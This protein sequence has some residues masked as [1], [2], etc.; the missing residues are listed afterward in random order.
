MTAG[1]PYS[2]QKLVHHPE[3]LQAM[4]EERPQAPIQ[5]HFMPALA[6]NQHCEFCS[7]GHRVEADGEEQRGWKNMALMSAEYLP[8]LK[9]LEL[10][11]DWAEMGVKAVE[12][13][14]GGEP[15]IYPHVDKFLERMADWRA[16]IA[17]VTNGTALTEERCAKFAA[18]NWK[19]ARVSIDAGKRET[20]AKVR[21]V[22][23]SHWDLA[24]RAVR[25]LVMAKSSREQRVGVGYVV[26]RHNAT[27]TDVYSAA[28]LAV[29][30]GADN[31]R[32]SLAF[33]PQHMERF[34]VE[35]MAAVQLGLRLARQEFGERF[36]IID[37][38]TERA[39]NI[40][41]AVQD[42]RMCAAK[43]VICVVGGDMNVYTC[44]TL[45]FN[46]KGLIGS[47][48]MQS[49][50][51]LW[52]ASGMWRKRHDA[53]KVCKV[54]CLYEARNRKALQLLEM[55]P[56]DVAAVAAGD[57]GLHRNFI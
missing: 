20:Y 53:R 48:R 11:A 51:E 21:R 12:L 56:A 39:Q 23:A 55:A 41:A 45:A 15:L 37:L 36:Q 32:F 27:A 19:W 35:R 47:I 3:A 29:E 49:F 28:A 13:T 43:E 33:T 10:V 42:Y 17:L 57:A 8:R 1:Q 25:R 18:T 30:H 38:V 14:G 22:P 4:R 31:I 52:D 2:T 46:P 54:P 34:G 26:D 44:C 7:Y 40:A 16:D 6:C 9:M 50:K 5:V 24:W